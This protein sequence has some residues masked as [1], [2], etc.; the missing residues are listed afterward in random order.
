MPDS[1]DQAEEQTQDQTLR[2]QRHENFENWYANNVQYHPSEWDLKMI[3]GQLDWPDG[4]TLVVEQHTGITVDW[5]QAKVMLYFLTLQVA[6][7]E[8]SHGKLQVPASV[9]PPEPAPPTEEDIKN[10]AQAQEVYELIKNMREHFF[11]HG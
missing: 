10:F 6:V 3:F 2:L 4:K 9:I 1:P 7:Y 8:L 11:S 5:I